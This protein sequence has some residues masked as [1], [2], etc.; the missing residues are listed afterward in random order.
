M[1]EICEV[2]KQRTAWWGTWVYEDWGGGQGWVL[3][4]PFPLTY[5]L[6]FPLQGPVLYRPQR[7]RW[8][9][10][11][12][13][14]PELRGSHREPQ[15]RA[16]A[17]PGEE[18]DA[19]GRAA[20][21]QR[22]GE[23]SPQR[24]PGTCW[25]CWHL[26]EG[27]SHVNP[28]RDPHCPDGGSFGHRNHGGWVN[29]QTRLLEGSPH[30]FGSHGPQFPPWR[31]I[32]KASLLGCMFVCEWVCVCVCVTVSKSAQSS[33]PGPNPRLGNHVRRRS[34]SGLH[35]PS[36]Q[37]ASPSCLRAQ[38]IMGNSVLWEEGCSDRLLAPLL[39]ILV[40][41]AACVCVFCDSTVHP[42]LSLGPLF[43]PQ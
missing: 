15:L 26:W 41:V 14:P 43:P 27:I 21:P 1:E 3:T 13:T 34:S 16:R 29:G 36:W 25:G 8:C 28:R 4:S 11:G 38:G 24:L 40:A 32:R 23:P 35:T 37:P 22:G 30:T 2:L 31:Q 18:W 9:L 33:T 19:P 10:W 12:G 20:G 39:V 5:L 6:L 42:T 7:G 17:D